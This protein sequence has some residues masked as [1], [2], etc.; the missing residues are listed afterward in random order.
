M[1]CNRRVRLCLFTPAALEKLCAALSQWGRDPGYDPTQVLMVFPKILL[2]ASI[3]DKKKSEVE[4][5]SDPVWLFPR[6]SIIPFSL[7]LQSREECY[8]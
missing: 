1:S 7:E 5:W 8:G 2:M 4:Q 6:L 3:E